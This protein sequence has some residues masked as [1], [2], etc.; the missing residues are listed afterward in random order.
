M[1]L[2]FPQDLDEPPAQE[3]KSPRLSNAWS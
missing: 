3:A 1:T 2:F